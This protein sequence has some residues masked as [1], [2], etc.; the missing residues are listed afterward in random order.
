MLLTVGH[1]PL[2]VMFAHLPM[3]QSLVR[4]PRSIAQQPAQVCVAV[5][6][7]RLCPFLCAEAVA[8]GNRPPGAGSLP[9]ARLRV[10]GGNPFQRRRVAS[11][12]KPLHA[13]HPERSEGS[14]C[15]ERSFATL[16]M[17]AVL[18]EWLPVQFSPM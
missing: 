14:L 7:A 17:T 12:T 5:G 18:I 4:S 2:L 16:R 3:P 13:C 8:V 1:S 10:E 11:Q 15:G 9:E 6:R